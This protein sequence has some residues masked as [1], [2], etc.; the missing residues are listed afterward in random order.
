MNIHKPH[1]GSHCP[2]VPTRPFELYHRRMSTAVVVVLLFGSG[3]TFAAD[4]REQAPAVN[5]YRYEVIQKH[6]QRRSP[7]TFIAVTFSGGGMRAASLA[8]GVLTALRDTTIDPQPKD[9]LSRQL[10]PAPLIS[11]VDFVSSVSGGSVTAT[12]W[13]LHGSTEGLDR[14]RDDFLK[15][16]VQNEILAR[17]FAITSMAKLALTKYS[18]S[19]LLREYFSDELFGQVTYRGLLDRT[20]RHQDRPYL[21]INATDMGTRSL[22][23]FVQLQFD[24]ICD[25]LGGYELA[26]A[27]AASAAYPMAF[28]AISLENRLLNDAGCPRQKR[29][30][31]QAVEE[32]VKRNR[33]KVDRVQKQWNAAKSTVITWEQ[34][35]REAN[36]SHVRQEREAARAAQRVLELER[37]VVSD[38]EELARLKKDLA[39]TEHERDRTD[40]AYREASEK[41][42]ALRSAHRRKQGE[43][44]ENI[45][46]IKD[47]VARAKEQKRELE[48]ELRKIRNS[49]DESIWYKIGS[50]LARIWGSGKTEAP[51]TEEYAAPKLPDFDPSLTHQ[52]NAKRAFTAKEK[53]VSAPKPFS[54]VIGSFAKWVSTQTP[55]GSGGDSVDSTTSTEEVD[56]PEESTNWDAMHRR[57]GEIERRSTS[58]EGGVV[59][60][61]ERLR[62]FEDVVKFNSN[63]ER[64]LRDVN[65]FLLNFKTHLS[66]LGEKTKE[67]KAEAEGIKNDAP[68]VA[69]RTGEEAA[70][71][72]RVGEL[73]EKVQR[74][75]E[76]LDEFGRIEDGVRKH[77]ELLGDARDYSDQQGKMIEVMTKIDGV[78]AKIAGLEDQVEKARQQMNNELDVS[79]GLVDQAGESTAKAYAEKERVS[80]RFERLKGEEERKDA[81]LR[82]TALELENANVLRRNAQEEVRR[83]RADVNEARDHVEKARA[84]EREKGTEL[85]RVRAVQREH[86]AAVESYLRQKLHYEDGDSQYVHLMDGGAADN[87]GFSPLVE[88]L[89]SFSPSDDESENETSG[90]QSGTKYVAVVVVDARGAPKKNVASQERSP[91][92]FDTL[93]ATIN[94]AIE[95]KSFLLTKELERVTKKLETDGVIEKRFVVRVDF[96]S[97]NR[98]N[99][100]DDL[101]TCRNAYR[102]IP[103]NWKLAPEVVDSLMEMGRALVLNSGDYGELVGSLRG[104]LPETRETVK[105]VC[106]K[107]ENTLLTMLEERTRWWQPNVNARREG[108]E[109]P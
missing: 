17:M 49:D 90:W 67:T 24:L 41:E 6:V 8:Y 106:R 104:N 78:D 23:P 27:V 103:T 84:A 7:D 58:I 21:V 68:N 92:V 5:E 32:R 50:A 4:L 31:Y 98:L 57:L 64:N 70:D 55:S 53:P 36:E 65:K 56:G 14:F 89:D 107:H 29:N 66:L 101:A 1:P 93:R 9:G 108:N 62:E 11:D 109:A 19:T 72:D 81:E 105:S 44:E 43:G 33:A 13:A 45:G 25:D 80:D 39:R 42:N 12:Q 87:L 22:F 73:A 77:T 51:R 15:V 61:Q 40:S 82:T 46:K 10:G 2:S 37:A 20:L 85:V 83:R 94:T 30:R 79:R 18:R 97:I 35:L 74:L 100:N 60:I 102:K 63:D 16:E 38:G 91:G 88:L 86:S 95:G 48:A 99:S 52:A 54:L 3:N 75:S 69:D 47:E 59:E 71:A 34:R 96:D 28:P 76:L 26:Q